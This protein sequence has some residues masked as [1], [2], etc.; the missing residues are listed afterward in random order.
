MDDK[1]IEIR[2]DEI[3]VEA[4]M[5]KIRENIRRRQ[6]A[7]E[8]P[9]DPDSLA[10][11]ATIIGKV[12]ITN[13]KT[14]NDLTYIT[15]NWDIHN[16][17]YFIKSHRPYI[18]K[19][20]IKGRQIV[21]E[22]V[23][24]YIDPLISRQTE[25]NA[26][27]VRLF[28]NFLQTNMENNLKISQQ[29]EL[30]A[31]KFAIQE[32][33]ISQKCVQQEDLISQKCVQQEDL[34]SQKCVQQEDLINQKCVQQEDLINQKFIQ[35]NKDLIINIENSVNTKFRNVFFQVGNDLKS[36]MG[37]TRI[38]EER[39]LKALSQKSNPSEVF[40]QE[41]INYFHFEEHYRG[42]REVIKQ[43]QIAF[44][45]YFKNCSRVLDLGCGRGEFLEILKENSIGG[46]GVD[47]DKDM[48]SYCKSR[49]L[50]IV[51]SDA[52]LYLENLEDQSLDGIFIDQVVEHLEPTYLIQLLVLCY[53]KMKS[54]NYIVVETVN[55]LSFI[56]F[57]NFYID[58]TH[59][60]PVHPETLQY[61]ISAAGFHVHETKFFTPVSE[62]GRLKRIEDISDLE[63][64]VR[65]NAGI[66]NHNI[67]LLNTVLFGAQDYA[68]I[69]KK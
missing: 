25:F 28:T 4:I 27:S 14:H 49:Q 2:D 44:L 56:S 41:D 65:K 36:Q 19:I 38:L 24:R 33:L 61:L 8:L 37:L 20:L 11:S 34:I 62:E 6:A 1:P 13:E 69:G 3:N 39:M 29:S 22:E 68:V 66:Y 10:E 23:R 7:G 40:K 30:F 63:G 54:G 12:N 21:H 67:D 45:P 58:L 16:N 43:R 55:P 60:R 51:Q 15:N 26:C 52:L 32:D 47:I 5:A 48:V 17:G 35:Q 57:A 64:T 50:D 46:T 42:S 9:P 53:Q 59:K 31:Q 18:G